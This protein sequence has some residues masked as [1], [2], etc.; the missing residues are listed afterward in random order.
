[1]IG[2]VDYGGGNI[3]SVLNAL[4]QLEMF[5]VVSDDPDTLAT[6]DRLIFPG[7][8]HAGPAMRNLKSKGLDVLIKSYERP[9]LGICL[10]MQLMCGFNEESSMGG[11]GLFDVPVKKF[12]TK[13]KVPHL[14]WNNI[15]GAAEGPYRELM[16]DRD[17]YF[18]HSYYVPLCKETIGTVEYDI[19]FSAALA[20]DNFFGFQ[21]HP[22]KS[23]S[24]GLE[25][26]KK[27]IEL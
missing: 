5:A 17:F 8:G 13:L 26:I 20:K 10:G 22:E 14:G 16:L 9:F 15:T 23:A 6:M 19:P 4:N 25:I 24:Q 18:V 7:V 27:F 2:I 1:M 11:L 21:F 3:R 12:R